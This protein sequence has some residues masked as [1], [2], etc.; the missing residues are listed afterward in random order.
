MMHVD[1][2]RAVAILAVLGFHFQPNLLPNGYLGVDLFLVISGYLITSNVMEHLQ[3]G[4]FS[5]SDFLARRIKRIM[6]QLFLMTFTS[7]VLS[8]LV[9]SPSQLKVFATSLAGSSGYF[10][11]FVFAT[12]DGYFDASKYSEPLLHTW[13]LSL[14]AQF[15]LLL[16]FFLILIWRQTST[17][18]ILLTGFGI[19]SFA[20]W[21][22][23]QSGM[24]FPTWGQNLAFYMLPSRAWEFL[25]G[26]WFAL[27]SERIATGLSRFAHSTLVGTLALLTSIAIMAFPWAFPSNGLI[28]LIVTLLA[29]IL[30]SLAGFGSF[31]RNFLESPPMIRIGRLSFALYVWHWPVIAFTFILFD[32]NHLDT[33]QTSFLIVLTGCIAYVTWLYFEEPLRRRRRSIQYYALTSFIAFGAVL[34]LA[35]LAAVAPSL[36]NSERQAAQALS[37]SEAVK[38]INLDGR[39]LVYSR[40][41]LLGDVYS[42]RWTA[43]AVGSSRLM[44]L[45]SS[46]VGS[47]TLNLSVEGAS[48]QD[49]IA[50]SVAALKNSS[51]KVLYLGID[52]FLWNDNRLE[53]RWANPKGKEAFDAAQ[54]AIETHASIES[55]NPIFLSATYSPGPLENVF[56]RINIS[57]QLWKTSATP[58][59]FDKKT[60]DGR[61]IYKMARVKIGDE[62]LKV[63]GSQNYGEMENFSLSEDTSRLLF[64]FLN[65]LVVNEIEVKIMLSPYHPEALS[66]EISDGKLFGD[67][68]SRA[69]FVSDYFDLPVYGSY[70]SHLVG[71]QAAEFSDGIH[72]HKSCMEKVFSN[73][74][75]SGQ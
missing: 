3:S 22:I 9:M 58:G 28:N 14:E 60:R 38:F 50:I 49:L 68:E 65:Y 54:R 62:T 71:C 43:I 39:D 15:Y 12:R 64:E 16:P 42:E 72:P 66:V 47:P 59:V 46:V 69:K 10:S 36:V 25:V 30:I 63:K 32:I 74:L 40:I 29:A 7:G 23:L 11:N 31:S 45:D 6:P 18:S 5:L 56:D 53:E 27:Y 75:E 19:A 67:L 33:L 51:A 44:Q 70:F 17:M 26:V 48:I 57:D 52:P 55:L 61:H 4:S 37:S 1:G 2:L 41:E 24:I 73:R 34:M 20:L 35:L 13:S 8:I 21:L